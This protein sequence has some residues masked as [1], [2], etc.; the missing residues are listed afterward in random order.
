MPRGSR[1]HR[2]PGGSASPGGQFGLIGRSP[3][4][5]E[6]VRRIERVAPTDATVL[7]LGERGTGKELVALA[8]ASASCHRA[9]PFVVINCAALPAELLASELFGHE[10]GAFTGAMERRAGLLVAAQGGTVFFDEVG[11]LAPV[12]Q[13]MLLRF[14][15]E[16][17]V[18]PLGT[19]TTLSVD[20]RVI[21]ATNRELEAAVRDGT[22]RADLHDRLSEVTITVPPLRD[23]MEDLLQLIDHFLEFHARRHGL[24]TPR[25]SPGFV[26]ALAGHAW[27]GNVRELE[28]AMSR[29]VIFGETGWASARDVR[30]LA[31]P[32]A[33][34]FI[35]V[36]GVLLASA[37]QREILGLVTLRRSV[38]RRDV[39]E[40]FGISREAARRELVALARLGFLRRTGHGRGSRYF[41]RAGAAEFQ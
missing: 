21:A 22:F 27:P 4:I 8:L 34:P 12:G 35:P 20:V 2:R 14:L 37:R 16:R 5:R 40:H 23:R 33:E 36:E 30:L 6:L 39:I 10:R 28:K 26:R 15:Q 1:E 24:P 38:S 7:I 25:L 29:A 32:P 3:A 19:T 13:A 17:E 31:H 11:D 9:R 41:G 18:R